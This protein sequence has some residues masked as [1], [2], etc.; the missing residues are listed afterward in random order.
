MG[1]TLEH[2]E[3]TGLW[4]FLKKVIEYG[5]LG[6]VKMICPPKVNWRDPTEEPVD[7]HIVHSL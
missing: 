6:L 4:H 2:N 1:L 5:R 7:I 3:L